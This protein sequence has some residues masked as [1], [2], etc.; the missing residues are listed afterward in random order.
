MLRC[1]LLLLMGVLSTQTAYGSQRAGDPLPSWAM[2]RCVSAN[3]GKG[4]TNPQ[5]EI[6]AGPKLRTAEEKEQAFKM[7]IRSQET[8]LLRLQSE[9]EASDFE[10]QQWR[11]LL[12]KFPEASTEAITTVGSFI[13]W[14]LNEKN[15]AYATKQWQQVVEDMTRENTVLKWELEKK[16]QMLEKSLAT[17]AE[18]LSAN[19]N[20]LATN[21][22]LNRDISS[23]D[24]QRLK[25]RRGASP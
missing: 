5:K 21:I 17:N 6:E 24:Q 19:I 10:A 20:L 11:T 8:T 9:L 13:R 25:A 4:R 15:A 7:V 23:L 14:M 18:L 22:D 3:S 12:K 1:T 16:G 2:P